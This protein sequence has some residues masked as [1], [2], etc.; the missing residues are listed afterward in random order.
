MV[1]NRLFHF[2]NFKIW[3]IIRSLCYW[4]SFFQVIFVKHLAGILC[5]PKYTIK[6]KQFSE[7][8]YGQASSEATASLSSTYEQEYTTVLI[9]T[10]HVRLNRFAETHSNLFLY[11]RISIRNRSNA[12]TKTYQLKSYL[13]VLAQ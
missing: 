13:F 3:I 9:Y 6:W 8:E 4:K 2:M 11:T 5:T 12:H 1:K 7:Q 10:T